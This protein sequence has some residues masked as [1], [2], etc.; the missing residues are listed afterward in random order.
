MTLDNV[1]EPVKNLADGVAVL[2]PVAIFFNALPSIAAL[3]SVVWLVLRIVIAVQ[4]HV[5]NRRKIKAQD[6]ALKSYRQHLESTLKE[7]IPPNLQR[8]LDQLK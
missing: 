2:T 7:G 5:L 4:E 1:S 8:L 3:L 6:E